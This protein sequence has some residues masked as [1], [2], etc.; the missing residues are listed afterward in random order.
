VSEPTPIPGLLEQLDALRA[1]TQDFAAREDR[2]N[3]EHTARTTAARQQLET[4]HRRLNDEGGDKLDQVRADYEARREANSAWF[5]DRKRRINRAHANVRKQV[6]DRV[7][8]TEGR[9]KF[10]IQKGTLTAERTR[11]TGLAQAVAHHAEYQQQL[12]SLRETG[13]QLEAAAHAALGGYGKFRRLL[14]PDRAWPEPDLAP[15][16]IQLFDRLQKLHATASEDLARFR[17]HPLTAIFR[18]LPFW[19]LLLLAAAGGAGLAARHQAWAKALPPALA[20]GLL[21]AAG[22]LLVIREV[23]GRQQAALAAKIAAALAQA[24]RLDGACFEKSNLRLTQTQ[25]QV[26]AD[27]ISTVDALNQRWRSLT[28]ETIQERGERPVAIDAQAQQLYQKCEQMQVRHRQKLENDEKEAI[29]LLQFS[30][31]TH[32]SRLDTEHAAHLARLEHDFVQA[33]SAL[34]AEWNALVPPLVGQLRAHAAAA[35]RIFPA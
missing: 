33:W 13:A 2:L 18:F 14:A 15:D 3:R 26:Q 6:L 12:A 29:A 16:E 30:K 28:K 34:V 23:G 35:E 1:A 22:L 19:L 8:T 7:A 10:A 32:Q 17:K 31:Q 9:E 20:P 11:E 24:R 5:A 21:A 27:Y 4:A 25:A